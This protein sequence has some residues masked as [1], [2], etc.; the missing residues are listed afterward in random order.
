[1]R[2]A[3]AS[4]VR[5]G[6]HRVREEDEDEDEGGAAN[7]KPPPPFWDQGKKEREKKG[8]GGG[9]RQ[10][11]HPQMMALAFI[12]LFVHAIFAIASSPQ[13]SSTLLLHRN[14]N[15]VVVV[16]AASSAAAA[17]SA[18][19]SPPFF[20]L[21][22]Y[23]ESSQSLPALYVFFVCPFLTFGAAM[24]SVGLAKLRPKLIVRL[25]GSSNKAFLPLLS[26]PPHFPPLPPFLFS[27][28]Y[29]FLFPS[30]PFPSTHC[31]YYYYYY[32][33]ALI[34]Q[35]LLVFFP[36]IQPPFSNTTHTPP[37]HTPPHPTLHVR[38]EINNS[39]Q[40]LQQYMAGWFG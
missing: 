24:K 26:L 35:L 20:S 28:L 21:S 31:Y 25:A 37:W 19:T 6:P 11:S 40:Q 4:R 38:K 14:S 39:R 5:I 27:L 17:D 13:S 34:T 23:F 30:L 10:G 7:D 15:L 29:S 36:P 9:G 16:V 3:R 32:K 12:H 33:Y 2:A 22:L 1:M 8:S 18:T